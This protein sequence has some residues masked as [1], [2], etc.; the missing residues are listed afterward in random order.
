MKIL[1]LNNSDIE[2]GAARATTRLQQGLRD[3]LIDAQLLVARKFGDSPQVIGPGSTFAKAMGFSR[4]TLEQKIFG[5]APGKINGPFSPSF[6]P[7]R[8]PAVVAALSPDI[9]HLNWVANMMRLETLS[10]FEVPIVW[11]LHDS[12]PFT[13]GCYVPFD[14]TRYREACGSCPVLGSSRESDLSRRVWMRKQRAWRGL[15]LTIVA[16]SSWMGACAKA[17][18]LFGKARI[19]VIPNGLDLHRFKP[20]DKRTA[21]E[22]L[23]L[24]QDKRLILFGAKSATSDR[25]KG[26]HLLAQALHELAGSRAP[27]G[28]IELVVFGASR[29]EPAPELGFPA[30]YLGWFS[31]EVSLALLYAA[32][33]VFVFPSLQESL[34]YT[35][36]EAMACGTPC[37][38]FNQGGIPD[39]IDHG[40][41][42]Y[43]AEPFDAADLARGIGWVLEAGKRGGDLSGAARGKVER[44]FSI[45]SVAARYLELYRSVSHRPPA[46]TS[47]L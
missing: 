21:R 19:E 8:I 46:G 43:L 30:H 17:S 2:S 36:M 5:I 24:P 25:N 41:N 18:S 31:D 20:V 13:G 16:P 40:I 22:M 29:P 6:L 47:P 32:A 35:A 44:D 10:R 14:C 34:G 12:W 42:G 9:I 33:D 15:D 26:F 38:A 28:S 45:E 37:V 4:P 39:L 7:D 1:M 27:D 3:K 23:S 11:T